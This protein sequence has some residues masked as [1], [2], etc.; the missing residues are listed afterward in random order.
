MPK[1]KS[2]FKVKGSLDDVSFFKNRNGYQARMKSGVDGDRIATDPKFKR[3]RENAAEFTAVAASMK[4]VRS[5]LRPVIQGIADGGM[6]GRL[7]RVLHQ[8]KRLDLTSDRGQ[9]T[10]AVGLESEAG[11][12]ALVGF[13]F[14]A[15][16][17]LETVLAVIPVLDPATG[18]VT[19]PGM[20]SERDLSIPDGATHYQL[21][22]AWS[23]VDFYTGK[24]DTVVTDLPLAP[25]D[26][27]EQDIVLTPSS[28]P[29]GEGRDLFALKLVFY[30]EMNGKM[31]VLS[32]GTATT[33]AI[34]GVA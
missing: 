17:P 7:S 12:E 3:T 8:V 31:Y 22:L 29:A 32:V 24:F 26:Q 25:L 16:A 18:V 19:L 6:N 4:V 14:N 28:T 15:Q 20:V 27:T 5:A 10:V 11:R 23:R 2:L 1:F 33:S 30:Q 13:P 9:R 21:G 34:I